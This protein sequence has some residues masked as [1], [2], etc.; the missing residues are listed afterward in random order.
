[1]SNEFRQKIDIFSQ[2]F[3]IADAVPNRKYK[4]FDCTLPQ[5]SQMRLA[6]IGLVKNA[7]VVVTGKAPLGDPLIISVQGYSLCLRA[8]QAKRFF[9]KEVLDER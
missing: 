8:E 3:S 2:D 7:V 9:V 1:M 5:D 6:Q 4:I